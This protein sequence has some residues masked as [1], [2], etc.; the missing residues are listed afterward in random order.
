METT[1]L[2][3]GLAVGETESYLLADPAALTKHIKPDSFI[4]VPW[5]HFKRTV[6]RIIAPPADKMDARQTMLLSLDLRKLAS[7]ELLAV[8][9][10]SA[11]SFFPELQGEEL[12]MWNKFLPTSYELSDYQYDSIPTEAVDCIAIAKQL[13][14]FDRIFICTPEGNTFG[15]RT[16]RGYARVKEVVI[17]GVEQV[18][19]VVYRASKATRAALVR[20]LDPLAI[21]VI[22]DYNGVERMYQIVRW[23]ES[24]IPVEEV[25]AHVA[26][27]DRQVQ[28]AVVL[29]VLGFA[30][31][32][33][34]I[35]RLIRR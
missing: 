12:A 3:A 11:G 4:E 30:G 32:V 22:T 1:T 34:S 21:G 28:N 26:K 24:L 23:G 13:G 18:F 33:A 10:E 16:K 19:S 27:V 15:G 5:W 35:A 8:R 29:S 17:A 9:L 7:A 2:P 6:D 14:C 20:T 31:I 25:K